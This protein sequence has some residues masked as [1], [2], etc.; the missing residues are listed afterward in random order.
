MQTYSACQITQQSCDIFLVTVCLTLC[1]ALLCVCCSDVSL[2]NLMAT[3]VCGGKS[4]H[5]TLLDLGMA[6]ELCGGEG[7]M[8]GPRTVSRGASTGRVL[9]GKPS[10]L[11]PEAVLGVCSVE[12]PL[13]VGALDVWAVGVVL[14]ILLTSCPLY[15]CP[16]DPAFGALCPQGP[17]PN[18]QGL[19]ELVSHYASMG[20]KRPS[21]GAMDLLRRLL[22]PLPSQRATLQQIA[23]HPWL[24]QWAPPSQ[25]PY[26]T[27]HPTAGGQH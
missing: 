9:R 23:N 20:L 13:D 4:V 27:T 16:E 12:G 15:S 24:A 1:F 14:F 8:E 26:T 18:T 6:S 19:D 25:R 2:E 11:A 17:S 22:H 7:P 3:P 10:Y 5:V 21:D